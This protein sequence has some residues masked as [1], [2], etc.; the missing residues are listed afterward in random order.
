MSDDEDEFNEID[1]LDVDEHYVSMSTE[2]DKTVFRASIEP[3]SRYIG[4]KH[5]KI[6]SLREQIDNRVRQYSGAQTKRDEIK[7]QVTD[8]L[9]IFP[10]GNDPMHRII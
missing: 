2:K 4:Q 5:I 7:F 1:D 6:T 3:D 9:N 8:S 10:A